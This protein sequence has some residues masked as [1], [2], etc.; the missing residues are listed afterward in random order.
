[1]RIKMNAIKG[2]YRE[3]LDEEWVALI[4]SAKQIGLSIEEVREFIKKNQVM[5]EKEI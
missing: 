1:M 3:T 2:K 4:L 5:E